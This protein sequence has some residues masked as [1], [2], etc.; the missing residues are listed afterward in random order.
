MPQRLLDYITDASARRT[1]YG[2]SIPLLGFP[3]GNY[4]VVFEVRDA[5]QA[6]SISKSTTFA[7]Y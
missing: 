2:V 7:I 5:I 3:R 4:S 1:A 6:K